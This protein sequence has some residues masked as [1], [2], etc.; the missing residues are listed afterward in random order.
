M[1]EPSLS[2]SKG[3]LVVQDYMKEGKVNRG[4]QTTWLLHRDMT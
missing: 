4:P 2:L 1:P 3:P